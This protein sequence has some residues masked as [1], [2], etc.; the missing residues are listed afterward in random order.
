MPVCEI[1]TGL[2]RTSLTPQNPQKNLTGQRFWPNY[3]HALQ[4]RPHMPQRIA[5]SWFKAHFISAELGLG[6]SLLS[7]K[8]SLVGE[9]NA[10][11][12]WRHWGY[13]QPCSFHTP[14]C[15]PNSLPLGQ[16]PPA[17]GPRGS[18]PT[19]SYDEDGKAGEGDE[20]RIKLGFQTLG[21]AECDSRMQNHTWRLSF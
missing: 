10:D 12:F 18:R 21:A 7:A 11:G 3:L 19:R 9:G 20:P 1:V 17:S 2:S 14:I 4:A 16:R 15:T 13:F 8:L 6:C 5:A